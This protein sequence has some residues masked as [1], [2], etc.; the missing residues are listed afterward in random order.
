MTRITKHPEYF[1]TTNGKV[2]SE[3]NNA[4]NKRQ[5][6]YQLVQTLGRDG[7]Y[8]V[9]LKGSNKRIRKV[10]RLVAETF[11]PNPQNLPVVNHKDGNKLNN[12]VTNLEWCTHAENTAHAIANKLLVPA[13]GEKHSSA[14]LTN[15]EVIEVIQATLDGFTND[16]IAEQYGVHP[17]YVSLIRHQKRQQAIWSLHFPGAT[18]QESNK[19][20]KS[21]DNETTMALVIAAL[22][23]TKSN[24]SIAKEFGVD[25]STISKIRN[26]KPSKYFLL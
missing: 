16:E 14:K 17:R 18:P 12:D 23:T 9:G 10:H 2:Y 7:Y 4:G 19:A 22:S 8:W 20:D 5:T 21:R 6:V 11:L 13:C 1:I 26:N 25:A 3:I 15:A 24:V